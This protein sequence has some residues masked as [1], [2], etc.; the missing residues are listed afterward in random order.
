MIP[1]ARVEPVL[2]EV[3]LSVAAFAL[4]AA[5][6][7]SALAIYNI[8]EALVFGAALAAAA[9]VL[10]CLGDRFDIVKPSFW[11][12]GGAFLYYFS[13][14]LLD[15]MN[16]E[17]LSNERDTNWFVLIGFSS[18]TLPLSVVGVLQACGRRRKRCPGAVRSHAR[19][20][21][22]ILVLL[23]SALVIFNNYAFWA[24][25]AISK[26]DFWGRDTLILG[27]ASNW[28]VV[29]V[30]AYL[31]AT[32][33]ETGATSWWAIIWGFAL[34]IVTAGVMGERDLFFV[35]SLCCLFYF[36]LYADLRKAPA[37]FGLVLLVLAVPV[38]QEMK[39]LFIRADDIRLEE[40][41]VVGVM[42]NE[43]ITTGR[44]LDYLLI[45]QNLYDE[46]GD[47]RLRADVVRGLVPGLIYKPQNTST[48]FEAVYTRRVLDRDSKGLAFSILGAGYIYG[49]V[50][51]VLSVS[52][53]IVTVAILISSS[54]RAGTAGF[55][56][57]AVAA[58]LLLWSLRGD[59]GTIMSSVVKQAGLPAIIVLVVLKISDVR[60]W[61]RQHM[62]KA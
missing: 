13:A 23:V 27:F 46:I 45:N 57:F 62:R 56:F 54:A 4:A 22:A 15:F 31:S 30:A 41:I 42:S 3:C 11:L 35:F 28:F 6:S 38:T 19:W 61:G 43:F 44:N 59:L 14:G 18:L 50:V 51:G 20:V 40:S 47:Q 7:L 55:A 9:A 36:Y 12:L 49:G 16:V 1:E 58:P 29:F 10:V 60:V 52:L 17:A 48:W 2:R 39:N 5:L 37:L 24:S 25:G 34:A 32:K 33:L 8:T 53:V 21:L 26:R